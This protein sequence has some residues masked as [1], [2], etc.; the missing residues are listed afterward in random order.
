MVRVLRFVLPASALAACVGFVAV[1]TVHLPSVEGVSVSRVAIANGRVSME[2]PRMAGFDRQQRA[3]KVKAE[4][5]THALANPDK[6]DL[7]TIDASVPF[8]D[9]GKARV[10]A[11][12]GTFDNTTQMLRLAD[13]VEVKGEKG[14]RILLKDASIDMQSGR[15]TTDKSVRVRDKGVEIDAD[16]VE[17]RDSGRKVHFSGRVRTVIR[18][19]AKEAQ[20]KR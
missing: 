5:A 17:V 14:M 11:G 18:Q 1:A 8:G 15:M 16:G 19:D 13:E 20:E 4:R 10:L 9:E 6:V 7:E 3:F 12:S 2:K